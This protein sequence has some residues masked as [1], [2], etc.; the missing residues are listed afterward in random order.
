MDV[1]IKILIGIMSAVIVRDEYVIVKNKKLIK[2]MQ[3]LCNEATEIML[4]DHRTTEFIL[5]LINKHHVPI[6]E[7]DCIVLKDL[8]I[9]VIN[10]D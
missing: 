4:K 8:G 5:S 1:R 10:K 6:D 3:G 9:E 2:H 7:F